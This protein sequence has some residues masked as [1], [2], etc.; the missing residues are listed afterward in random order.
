MAI[1]FCTECGARHEYKFSAPKFC[2]SCGAP[3]G[4]AN[5][6]EP[7]HQKEVSKKI[8][9]LNENETDAESVPRITKLEYEIDDFGTNVNHTLGSLG[10]RSA[11]KK[12][13][14]NTKNIND[15]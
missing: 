2:S 12:F 1:K 15:L 14:S 4:V 11:P 10:G 8:T 3:M 5:A 13:R 6:S 9:T 7:T